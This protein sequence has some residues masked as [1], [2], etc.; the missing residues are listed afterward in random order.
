MN[1]GRLILSL[2]TGTKITAT[3]NVQTLRSC[4]AFILQ[5]YSADLHRL[6]IA[7]LTSGNGASQQGLSLTIFSVC[8]M[9]SNHAW[10]E[11]EVAHSLSDAYSNELSK[12]YESTRSLRLLIKLG[13]INE[14]PEFGMD[15]QWSE[16]G[17]RYVSVY[18]P[19]YYIL[20]PS[21][22]CFLSQSNRDFNCFFFFW[23]HF[24][25]DQKVL[26]LFR[27]YIFHQAR[28][29][30]SPVLDLGHIITSLNK[31]DAADPEKIVLVSR[32]GASLL[33]VSYA[34]ISR[35]VEE[36]YEELCNADTT[37]LESDFGGLDNMSQPPLFASGGS[38]ARSGGGIGDTRGTPRFSHHPVAQ[39][40]LHRNIQPPSYQPS[41]PFQ[42]NNI[43]A[44]QQPW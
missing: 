31:L 23:L 16:T 15:T 38:Q 13:L 18:L 41:Y 4:E 22:I 37:V 34:D 29:D 32:D 12:C 10:E 24:N 3:T 17:D 9:M 30:G 27:D 7:L 26:K 11:L 28:E 6:V 25:L 36:A 44:Q 2:T 33:V 40:Q 5:K 14:R 8:T 43:Y 21:S 1:L 20:L 39:P 35:C 42:Q 19:S